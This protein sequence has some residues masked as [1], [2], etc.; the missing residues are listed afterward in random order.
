MVLTQRQK[1]GRLQ[2]CDI[3]F[4]KKHLFHHLFTVFELQEQRPFLFRQKKKNSQKNWDSL[5]SN[6][7]RQVWLRRYK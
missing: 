2:L 4:F 3:I 1:I 7:L 5:N 6:N